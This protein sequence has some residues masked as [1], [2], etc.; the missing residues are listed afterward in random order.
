MPFWLRQFLQQETGQSSLMSGM[1]QHASVATA[2]LADAPGVWQQL[3]A[4]DLTKANAMPAERR[5]AAPS[6]NA[7]FFMMNFQFKLLT[8]NFLA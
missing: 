1:L 5:I 4:P 3:T 8:V 6:A 2:P 7:L